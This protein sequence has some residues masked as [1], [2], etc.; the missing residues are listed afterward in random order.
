MSARNRARRP[1]SFIS[2]A[3]NPV[4]RA[5]DFKRRRRPAG[6]GRQLRVESLEDRRMLATFTVTNVMD[7]PVA[8]AGDLQGSLRQ[9]LFDAN[10]DTTAT[11][12]DI[13]FNIPTVAAVQT[14]ELEAALVI[15]DGVNL[16][17][18]TQPRDEQ[19]VLT[20]TVGND[21]DGLQISSAGA[22][23][24]TIRGFVINDFQGDG[25]Q[26]ADS[27][28]NFIRGNLIGLD[29]TGQDDNGNLGAGVFI[30]GDSD[31]NTIGGSAIADR[32]IISGNDRSGIEILGGAASGN[33]I[34][35]NFIGT[36]ITGIDA[37]A[38]SFIGVSIE[39]SPNNT[40]GGGGANEGNLISG[41]GTL[42][43]D[44][45]GLGA[46][47]N[48]V[49]GNLIG[50]DVTGQMPLGN[51]G[52]GVVIEDAPNNN[53]GG[54]NTGEGN[55]ISGNGNQGVSIINAGATGN[56]VRGNIIGLAE[57]GTT[58]RPNQQNG[59][60]IT[61]A[62]GNFVGGILPGEGNQ[63][64][65]NTQDG[66]AVSVDMGVAGGN[67][68]RRNSIFRNVGLGIDLIDPTD[69]GRTAND[70]GD[71]DPGANLLQNFPE[72]VGDAVLDND[73]VT[74]TYR[75][76]SLPANSMFPLAIEFFLADADG[77]EGMTFLAA[78]TYTAG[79]RQFT[80]D[81]PASIDI[82]DSL[83][84][85]AT[86]AA[87][88]TSEF[89]DSTTLAP[90]PPLVDVSLNEIDELVITDLGSPVGLNNDIT[91][92][93][94]ADDLI[95]QSANFNIQTDIPGSTGSGT[96]TVTV[97]LAAIGDRV[98]ANLLGGNDTL[99]VDSSGGLLE[100]A[101]GIRFEGG[102]G[103]DQLNVTQTGGPERDSERVIIGATPGSGIHELTDGA[104]TQSIDFADL[105]PL[106]FNVPAATFEITSVAGL[107]SLLQDDNQ[108][109]Y[110]QG[111]PPLLGP[112]A[113]RVT[114]DD[115]EPIE[116]INK[117]QLVIEAGAGDD[118]I[119]LNNPGAPTG[120]ITILVD[121]G[122]P[123]SGDTVIVSGMAAA[124]DA[125]I[126]TAF[127]E[128]GAIVTGAQ[129]DTVTLFN[130]DRLIIDGQG[131]GDTL[132]LLS[133]GNQRNYIHTPGLATDAGRFD[134]NDES[135]GLLPVEYADLGGTGVVRVVGTGADDTLVAR[136]TAGADVFDFVTAAN[137]SPEIDLTTSAGQHIDLDGVL[138]EN[139]TIEALGDNDTINLGG[140]IEI[141]GDLTIEGGDSDAMTDV[142]NLMG[143]PGATNVTIAPNAADSTRQIVQGLGAQQDISGV[144]LINFT[145]QGGDDNLFVDLGVG[146]ATARVQNAAQTLTDQVISDRLPVVQ[147]RSVNAF[148]LQG[149]DEPTTATFVLDNLQGATSYEFDSDDQSDTL[150]IEG[151]GG[152]DSFTASLDMAGNVQ[153]ADGSGHTITTLDMT[154]TDLLRIESSGGDDSLM[155]DVDGTPVIPTPIFFDG[156]AGS[157][158]LT[159]TGDA[160]PAV[161]T[162]TYTPGLQ[163]DEGRLT[164]DVDDGAGGQVVGAMRIDFDNL[165][166]VFELAV[167]MNL[168][169]NGNG[170]DN[171]ITY[172]LG[173]AATRGLVTIDSF[174]T[175]EFENKAGLTID[176]MAGD[177]TLVANNANLPTG[178][179]GIT[180][181]GGS[182]ADVIRFDNLPIAM[183][184]MFE[185]AAGV[186]GGGDDVI[187]ASPIVVATPIT[188][189]GEAGNDTLTGGAGDDTLG[190]AT[191]DDT[192]IDSPGNDTYLGGAG[193]DTIVIRGTVLN[194]VISVTQA[195][196]TAGVN[197]QY[198]LN[199]IQGA[200]VSNNQV[201]KT[202]NAVAPNA[203][204]NRPDVERVVIE[205]QSGA[206]IIGVAHADEYSDLDLTNGVATQTIRFEVS[207]DGPN[208][209]DRLVVQDAGLGDLV[210]QRVGADQRSGS[211]TVGALAP[212]DYSAIEFV[213]VTPLN[214]ITGGTGTDGAGRLVVF[215]NDPFESNNT[216]PSAT[217]LGA[218]PTINVDPT[219]DPGGLV[220]PFPVP[221]DND[222][223]QFVAQET[224]TLDLQLYFEPIGT[225][226]NGRAGLPADGELLATVLDSDGNPVSIATA[227]DLNDPTGA[228]IGERVTVPVV[229]NN[230]YYLRVEGQAN[231]AG[232]TGIN[233]YNFTAI[234]TPAPIPELV[235][236]QAATDS[237]RNNTD[238]ITFFDAVANGPAV[239]DIVLDDARIDEFANINLNPDTV[240]DDAQTLN[241]A[242]GALI[243]YGVEVFNNAESIGF[244][245]FTGAGSTWRFTATAGDLNEGDFN[246]I[247]AAVWIRDVANP[248]QIGRH[249][250]SDS[251]QVELDTI[252]PPVQFGV[253][254][255]VDGLI[256]S[257]DTGVLDDPA[258]FG[259]RI[260]SDTTPGLVG[261]AEANSIV[262]V[263][264]DVNNNDVLDAND[265]L[266]GQ[267]T[268]LPI[269]GNLAEPD[270]FWELESVAD[271]NTLF[272]TRDGF[273]RLF[274]TAEDV[275]GNVNG[276]GQQEPLQRLELFIDTQGPQVNAVSVGDNA[277]Y[278]L[279]D[280]KPSVN[281]FTPLVN[282]LDIDFVDLPGRAVPAMAG[283][284]DFQYAALA[285][286][287]IDVDNY[288]LVG[289]HVGV[290]AIQSLA[291]GVVGNQNGQPATQRVTLNFFEPLPDDRYTLTI[292]DNITD[293]VGNAL[294]GESNADEPQENPTFPSGDA[295][296]GGDFVA[297]FTIDSRPEI[298]T[299]VAQ[300]INLD[301]N[302]NFV[303]D[304]ATAQIGGDATNV[305]LSF[306]LDRA[307][308]AGAN[309]AGG[310]GVHDLAF[311]GRFTN[312][313]APASGN[314]FDQLA[315]YGWSGELGQRR[316]IID[317]DSDGVVTSGTDIFTIQP[318]IGGFS[319]AAAI[320][321][322]GNFDGNLANGDEIG[323]YF[324]G[325]WALDTNRDFVISGG[326]VSG[327]GNLFGHPI[328]GD[329]DGDGDDDFAV[330]N[331]NT[332]RFDLTG[333]FNQDASFVWGFPGVLDRPVAADFDQDGVDDIGLFVPRN[334]AQPDRPQAEWYLLLSN[335]PTAANRITNTVNTLNHP[336]EPVP[337][338]NDLYAE[339][340]DELALPIVGNF[341]PPVADSGP[342]TPD[343]T[344]DG[345]YDENGVVDA[346]DLQVWR[347]AF[348]SAGPMADGN[349]DGRVDAMDYA[350][351]R[352][353]LGA[354][355]PVSSPVQ[356]PA[357]LTAGP[358]AGVQSGVA[359]GVDVF[360]AAGNSS[361]L[362][363]P[364]LA[365]ADVMG[366][367]DSPLVGPIVAPV[368]VTAASDRSAQLLLLEAAFELPEQ[369]AA[370]EWPSQIGEPQEETNEQTLD[371][372]F[373]RLA[374]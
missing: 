19:I 26:I 351:W 290:V 126:V 93:R 192:L 355:A 353:N 90:A 84:A 352:E 301:T 288:Q 176:G 179:T 200:V 34:L 163:P 74:L 172:T 342:V 106:T 58:P 278:D 208:S 50:V 282:S 41:N 164:Y 209:G 22:N 214:P 344:L 372:F 367:S 127:A 61:D 302:G 228:K 366:A 251:L 103:F 171:Q 124:A 107:A 188:L 70:A 82:G 21:F 249:A 157:D 270:G 369:A 286:N 205:G 91:L 211:V 8:A 160:M 96:Q 39:E 36:D 275:A 191:G 260:T 361:W 360:A 108:I 40:V 87:G 72:F 343:V 75:V 345:D 276:I 184:G 158:L 67:S 9:A 370:S 250:L 314:L 130:A 150:I 57:D 219:I 78:D 141:D 268:A 212:V 63:I 125:I 123:T 49:L 232:M 56:R 242:G 83:V 80:F 334:S 304:P 138:I 273:R 298:G 306:T 60:L 319:T 136:G 38:N 335:D 169:V 4:D 295:I 173:S 248:A 131:G 76:D 271:L 315:A 357:L 281:G 230:T 202:M 31:N 79:D 6:Y 177:D 105:E 206:D 144:E 162:T 81:V 365:A 151:Q 128:T 14:I 266:I 180:L 225:L 246:H 332:F 328:V 3:M 362:V 364:G 257:S 312:G 318:N 300:N 329:F 120:L 149:S 220:L 168:L 54:P 99:T 97:P 277:G 115:F 299:F 338:G 374:R 204:A 240:N 143:L 346:L 112:G 292:D 307:N 193:N 347:D 2:F 29:P 68:I 140:M 218:G 110:E 349:G 216:L 373:A 333:D 213:D 269:D 100:F 196:P 371:D 69:G 274:V 28:N 86:D 7:G 182:G 113:G 189:A 254:T 133:G 53:I 23:G 326:E 155:V 215:K 156:G 146:G 11:V 197:D 321:I 327:Q 159:V 252:I 43:V 294:D 330:F 308:A 27:D 5:L 231:A 317:T 13:V 279:F 289:D 77:Q 223:F 183:A 322:A 30:S 284:P 262:R 236:L 35:N 368:A 48:D 20:Q 109:N 287:G 89:S 12:D 229:R 359:T 122:D 148:Q 51:A 102:A 244:A 237:G 310:Y 199:V 247:S 92:S 42:G 88:N 263:F 241:D 354:T 198:A 264:A 324:A 111:T 348:G 104:V 18:T 181:G 24:S 316:W 46:T 59:V 165:E 285:A 313:N 73:Q 154:A 221:G 272:G 33:S 267:T 1:Q 186:G 139:I 296:P 203:A 16:D 238:D 37:V 233:V 356:S 65:F 85:T 145:G 121:G 175:I 320:P 243:H 45:L 311:A 47:G 291:F 207:G 358:A 95:I 235:D 234:T 227:S 17:A 293:P 336:F 62:S 217:F 339:F 280:P 137:G 52:G 134:I 337:F 256:D 153:V 170:D 239:F 309:I 323:L 259:D 253:P 341:D 10:A 363:M 325:R 129:F 305:D 119:N 245:F 340:G 15:T 118:T 161:F 303:W 190:G 331:D 178:L 194:D 152:A 98:I 55:V 283:D 222:F 94:D 201:G 350:V 174:E 147:F 44:I 66:V 265:Q 226:A 255:N 187:D 132:S 258:T 166:P 114:I 142:L 210:I 64:G 261:L 32:N 117:G 101:D 185:G 25:I 224:G 167:A 195:A 116:F 71:A 297:R 135:T